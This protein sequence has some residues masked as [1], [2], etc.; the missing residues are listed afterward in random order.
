MA[1]INGEPNKRYELDLWE[2]NHSRD[3][4]ILEER[5]DWIAYKLGYMME[6]R[7]VDPDKVAYKH[8]SEEQYPDGNVGELDYMEGVKVA[9]MMD[10]NRH[11]QTAALGQK[12][13][14]KYI[15]FDEIVTENATTTEQA[16]N[17]A[18][19]LKAWGINHVYL[20]GDNTSNQRAGNYGRTGKNDWQY[21]KEV[22]QEN[23]I[24]FTSKLRKQN[25]KRKIRVDKVSGIIYNPLSEERRLVI[26]KRCERAIRD[27]KESIID[28]DGLKIDN[29]KI[30][31][32]S[33]GCDYWIFECESGNK[34][35]TYIL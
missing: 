1:G 15:V 19:K 32:L 30:G 31:H 20:Y 9:L 27:Y 18:N 13:G 6:A 8:F 4:L 7:S 14:D 26:N 12:M 28:D 23:G 29:G 22:L 5:S 34:G 21:V 35:L 2:V 24:T 3:R 33:D 11:I 25:P 10:F 16:I 17:I